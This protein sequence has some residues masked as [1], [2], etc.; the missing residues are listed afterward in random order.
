MQSITQ[1]I[2]QQK[3]YLL[4][5]PV[6]VLI[7]DFPYKCVSLVE[8]DEQ[9]NNKNKE[10]KNILQR[11][12]FR[13]FISRLFLLISFSVCIKFSSGEGEKRNILRDSLMKK[14]IHDKKIFFL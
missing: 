11:G 9:N 10:N 5:L 14:K 3:N 13:S 8:R 1:C 2:Y 4:K 12:I 6:P 7:T